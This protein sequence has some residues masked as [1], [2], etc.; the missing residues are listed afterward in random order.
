MSTN[1]KKLPTGSPIPLELCTRLAEL[2]MLWRQKE[3]LPWEPTD[4]GRSLGLTR[5]TNGGPLL[6]VPDRTKLD[7]AL[8]WSQ[9]PQ[10]PEIPSDGDHAASVV[11]ALGSMPLAQFM[12]Y[13]PGGFELLRGE[14]GLGKDATY[15]EAAA[16][17]YR[18]WMNSN[19]T[20]EYE[21]CMDLLFVLTAPFY[22]ALNHMHFPPF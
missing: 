13:D 7:E 6:A 14:L 5:S 12:A 10:K 19:Q 21:H 4:Y 2:R 22:L 8:A 11:T 15:Q 18:L 20:E 17:V 16:G 3:D 9:A 1:Q